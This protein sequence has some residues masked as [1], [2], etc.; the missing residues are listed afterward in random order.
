MNSVALYQRPGISITGSWFVVGARR[1]SVSELSQLHTARGPHDPLTVRAVAV[2]GVLLAGIG[3]ALG[4]TGGLYH[5]T[6]AAYLTLGVA[7]LVPVL[8]AIIGHRWR[9]PAYELWG[10]YRGMT[11]LL[12]S[13]DQEREFGQVTRALLRAR[14]VARLG[15]LGEPLVSTADIWYPKPR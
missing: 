14:E 8:L 7:A 13:S 4:Y 5:L 12:F 15:G 11:M 1:Y 10:N 3:V 6:A 9:P 2:T